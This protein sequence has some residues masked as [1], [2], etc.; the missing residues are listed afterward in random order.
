MIQQRD[1]LYFPIG[2]YY[3]APLRY[4]MKQVKK[5]VLFNQ[6]LHTCSDSGTRIH[7]QKD[8]SLGTHW[9][10]INPFRFASS[11]VLANIQFV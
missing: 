1:Y 7:I 11:S 5:R 6:N 8:H 9:K 3:T 10:A 4:L 2:K